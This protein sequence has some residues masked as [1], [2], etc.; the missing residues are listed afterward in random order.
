MKE[1]FE[2]LKQFSG[3]KKWLAIAV[4]L[5]TTLLYMISCTTVLT[6]SKKGGGEQKITISTEQT[7][8]VDSTTIKLK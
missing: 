3:W 4:A 7:V 1:L 5:A 2:W 8:K 6:T